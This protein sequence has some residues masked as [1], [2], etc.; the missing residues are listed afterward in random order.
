MYILHFLTNIMSKFDGLFNKTID[1]V[2]L[3]DKNKNILKV[4][5]VVQLEDQ[6]GTWKIIKI[7][8]ENITLANVL[9]T[10]TGDIRTIQVPRGVIQLTAT[11]ASGH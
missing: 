10:K 5:D 2:E 11:K 3:M 1:S 4:S 9:E 6:K 8:G 7:K